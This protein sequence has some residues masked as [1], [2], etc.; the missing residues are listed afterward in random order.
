VDLILSG[1]LHVGQVAPSAVRYGDTGWASL[2]VQAGTATSTRRRGEVNAFNV[3][4]LE[5][6]HITVESL[7]WAGGTFRSAS[8]ARF[9]RGPK[10]W[11]SEP[12]GDGPDAERR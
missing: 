5:P 4:R 3:I 10:G 1:H 8:T 7:A 6:P 9:Q 11:I 12:F 2:L